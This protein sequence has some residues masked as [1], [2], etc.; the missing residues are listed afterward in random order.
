M[1][2]SQA[3]QVRRELGSDVLA[4]SV[5]IEEQIEAGLQ[6]PDSL[7][8]QLLF[9]LVRTEPELMAMILGKFL[10]HWIKENL[11]D[12]GTIDDGGPF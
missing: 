11:N 7:W 9:T 12:Y 1:T 6:V 4:V 3:K 8:C 5:K 2:G 10:V